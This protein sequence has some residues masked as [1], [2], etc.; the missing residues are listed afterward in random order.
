MFSHIEVNSKETRVIISNE[1]PH[2]SLN[3]FD[4][5]TAR[6]TAGYRDSNISTNTA[7]FAFFI[8]TN[9]GNL[10]NN[11]PIGVNIKTNLRH[12]IAVFDIKSIFVQTTVEMPIFL[13]ICFVWSN[14]L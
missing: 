8:H 12:H 1:Y 14:V 13:K 5:T 6:I 3:S 4:R 7:A 10:T 9:S 2:L 11:L